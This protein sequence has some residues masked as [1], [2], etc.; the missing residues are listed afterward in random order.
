MKFRCLLSLIIIGS[1]FRSAAYAMQ[2]YENGFDKFFVREGYGQCG[3]ASFYMI[4][5]YYGDERRGTGFFYTE[6][7]GGD[8]KNN[9]KPLNLTQ[10][11]PGR[12]FPRLTKETDVAKW[13]NGGRI[14]TEWEELTQKVKGLFFKD[15]GGAY[16]QYYN[17]T[18]E[19]GYTENSKIGELE[20]KKRFINDIYAKFLRNNHP[21]IVHLKRMWPFPGHYL[22]ITGFDE[23]RQTVKYVDPNSEYNGVIIQDIPLDD[24]IVDKWYKSPSYPWWYPKARWDGKW[25]GFYRE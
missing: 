11:I 24:F 19:A 23:A 6:E 4:F 22:V 9:Y 5:K 18:D 25:L 8:G 15:A 2:P 16:V 1:F 13:I 20:R 7:T 10:P 21:V 17:I 14:Q 12:E 3:T